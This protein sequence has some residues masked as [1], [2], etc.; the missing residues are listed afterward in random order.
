MSEREGKARIWERVKQ[1]MTRIRALSCWAHGKRGDDDALSP[2]FSRYGASGHP[3]FPKLRVLFVG[4]SVDSGP[5][6]AFLSAACA[7][8]TL[9]LLTVTTESHFT[10]PKILAT[11]A[12]TNP[13][14]MHLKDEFLWR[15][16]EESHCALAQFSNLRTAHFMV[17]DAT[18]LRHLAALP[19]LRTL[20]G[21]F[22]VSN[23]II[24]IDGAFPA[25][26]ELTTT[27]MN[28]RTDFLAVLP[29]ITS[30][31][32]TY[33]S[34]LVTV[35]LTEDMVKY[36]DKMCSSPAMAQLRKLDLHVTIKPDQFEHEDNPFRVERVSFGTD[37][38]ALLKRLPALTDIE[39]VVSLRT[40]AVATLD[41]ND[42]DMDVIASA[43]PDLVRAKFCLKIDSSHNN[44]DDSDSESEEPR[45]R[46]GRPSLSAIVSIGERCRKL[47]SLEIEFANVGA[48]ELAR[49]EKRADAACA[50]PQTALRR[51]VK[52]N[53]YTD[54]GQNF[55]VKDPLRLVAALRKLFPNLRGGLEI[56]WAAPGGMPVLYRDW[57]PSTTDG[58]AFRLLKALDDL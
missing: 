7:S 39:V 27:D 4:R 15:L 24:D 44:L 38:L 13:Q 18:L 19:N 12:E 50:S 32:L 48:R 45:V 6:L 57:H 51:I 3:M 33:L 55:R 2:I 58:D 9:A 23:P 35:P 52:V 17:I 47:E 25:L 42:K 37:I 29:L 30:K 53:P 8:S 36:M 26:Q 43:W 11:V 22:T 1:I 56:M 46:V 28:D 40:S 14:I 34:L 5:W 10:T 21:Q 49:L 20:H 41:M 16:D 54:Y 31:S